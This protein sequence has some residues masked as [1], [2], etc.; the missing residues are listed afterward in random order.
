MSAPEQIPLDQFLESAS[1]RLQFLREYSSLVQEAAPRRDEIEQL[2]Q[3]AHWLGS[4]AAGQGFPLFSEIAGRMAHVF[5]YAL[6]AEL[7]P[8]SHGPLVEFL[9]DAITLL[10]GDLI[11]ID[12]DRTETAED[13][14][15]FKRRYSFAFAQ[16]AAQEALPRS[17]AVTEE[18]DRA[19][20]DAPAAAS[21]G[22][23]G[24]VLPEDEDVP[25]EVLEFF[26]P[27]ADE[28]LQ[29]VT[30][31][32]LAL[33]SGAT[34]DDVHRLFRAMHTVKGSAAQVGLRRV[35]AVAHRMEDLVG[36][37]RDGSLRA[38][39]EVVDLCLES[40]DVLKKTIHR[41]WADEQAAA[42]GLQSIVERLAPYAPREAEA[43]PAV[44][45]AAPAETEAKPAGELL[46]PRASGQRRRAAA[47]MPGGKS[48]RIALDRLDRMMNAV[49]ELVI[50]R[51]R[52]VGRM[53]ELEKLVE[54]LNFSKSR[55]VGKI[56]DF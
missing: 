17:A 11:Q 45:E 40:V 36:R 52:M 34:Q 14:E 35:S 23:I 31:C 8:E 44:Q 54:V 2:F 5:Q 7:P 56:D 50:N 24:E 46:P 6:H 27:E 13:V 4:E 47:A 18:T 39:P 19:A 37:I 9:A 32:L 38:T 53:A 43:S 30:E 48:V 21:S 28:H 10:E 42:A 29:A 51:T 41:Q 26:V 15:T 20:E 55:L 16:P 33:E 22:E 3:A 25:A 12:S 1:E 49:G